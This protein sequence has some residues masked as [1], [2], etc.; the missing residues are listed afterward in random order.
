VS[1]IRAATRKGNTSHVLAFGLF[2][3][4]TVAITWPLARGLGYLTLGPL[5]DDLEFIWKVWWFKRSVIDLHVSPFFNPDIYYPTGYNLA[6][7]EMTP[8]NTILA[9]PVT[10]AFGPIVGYNFMIF[11]SFVLSAFGT[12]LLVYYLTGRRM[13]GV[14]SGVVFAFSPF[15]MAHSDGHL[16][17]IATQ[18]LPF[19]LLCLE[20]L[21]RERRLRHSIAGAML[22]SLAALSAWY[23]AL[24][25]VVLVPLYLVVRFRPWRRYLL[26]PL[27]AKVAGLF[28]ALVLVA[29]LPFALPYLQLRAAQPYVQPFQQHLDLSA[30]VSNLLGPSLLHP[31]WGEWLRSRWNP[32]PVFV[33]ERSISLGVA[34]LSLALLAGWKGRAR[35]PVQAFGALGLAAC[36]LAVGPVLHLGGSMVQLPLPPVAIDLLRQLGVLPFLAERLDANL[37]TQMTANGNLFLPLPG[38]LL[39][40]FFPGFAAMRAW[41]RFGVFAILAAAVLAGWGVVFLFDWLDQS[42]ATWSRRSLSRLPALFAVVVLCSLT[43]FEFWSTVPSTS[44]AVESR[45]VDLWLRGQEGGFA[46]ME[47]PIVPSRGRHLYHS[48]IHQKKLIL[49]Y[50]SFTPQEFADSLPVLAS[51]PSR[52]SLELLHRFNVRYVLLDASAYGDGLGEVLL[53]CEGL[54]DLHLVD[55]ME[56]IYL[57]EL[58]R[59]VPSYVAEARVGDVGELLGY[60]LDHTLVTPQEPLNLT[61]FWLGLGGT[62]VAYK[63]F[64]HLINE[65][66]E[67]VAQHDAEPCSWGCPTTGWVSQGIMLDEHAIAIGPEAQPGQYAL[68]VGMYDEATGKRVPAYNEQGDL[69]PEGAIVLG[70]VR[71]QG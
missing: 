43:L 68:V 22:C 3:G 31:V 9:L 48:I 17:V 49:G 20:R 14:L 67:I 46:I 12:Y 18:W 23:Y 62:E 2:A 47:F 33:V 26:D 53:R 66:G 36:I 30:S 69:L 59:P 42:R 57:Y 35:K 41:A 65:Q 28:S 13:A 5:G 1:L 6:L 27:V 11:I 45:H 58:L 38:L 37:V 16:S 52:E 25:S 10:M 40:L 50:S 55:E 56:G 34:P 39:Y 60:D 70:N 51:F 71:V 21:F 32:S 63:I 24:Y 19:L 8:A 61:L 64:T 29:V 44:A 7:A 54:E 15:R 4:L